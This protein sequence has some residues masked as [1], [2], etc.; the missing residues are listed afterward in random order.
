MPDHPHLPSKRLLQRPHLRLQLRLHPRQRKMHH[1]QPGHSLLPQER[2]LQRSVVHLRVRLLPKRTGSLR[3]LPHRHQLERHHLLHLQRLRQRILP[4]SS[5]R[6]VRAPRTL[7]RRQCR[8][9]RSHLRLQ[10]R[11]QLDQRTLPDLP[12][13]HLLRRRP[14]LLKG[15]RKLRI[16]PNQRQW[17]LCLQRRLLRYQRQLPRLSRKHQ[18]ERQVLRLRG[19]QHLPVVPRPALLQL[20]RR[21]MHMHEW[22]SLSQ[23]SLHTH[24]TMTTLII[25][26]L[27]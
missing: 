18:V 1:R 26:I 20:L 3:P 5:L 22:I 2:L 16:Q 14:M 25:H 11:L 9:E 12:R 21:K 27:F 8:L 13:R 24:L 7:L 17:G 15:Q 10:C 4:Q 19:L 23:R 6:L